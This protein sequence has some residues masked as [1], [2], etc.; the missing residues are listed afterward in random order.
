VRVVATPRGARV[1]QL[2]GFSP[3]VTVQDLPLDQPQELLIYREGY[4]PLVRSLAESDFEPKGNR[5]VAE[6]TVEL[7]KH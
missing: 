2:I 7:T 3:E 5:R 4:V 6:L 1:Y